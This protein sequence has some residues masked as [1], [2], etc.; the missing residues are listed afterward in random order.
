MGGAS[1]GGYR[2][3]LQGGVYGRG[4]QWGVGVGGG[5]VWRG[6]FLED[7]PEMGGWRSHPPL[8]GEDPIRVRGYLYGP[9]GPWHGWARAPTHDPPHW[10]GR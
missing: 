8:F 1:K 6:L 9:R 3:G 10:V 5:G 2:R 7:P 4:L